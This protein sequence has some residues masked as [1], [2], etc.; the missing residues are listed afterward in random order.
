VRIAG[1]KMSA[2]WVTPFTRSGDEIQAGFP[3]R[4][5]QSTDVPKKGLTND[6]SQ[7]NRPDPAKESCQ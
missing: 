4:A 2:I 3:Y 5:V 7:P 1:Q 6:D